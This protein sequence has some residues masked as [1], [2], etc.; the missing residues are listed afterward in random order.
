MNGAM[1]IRNPATLEPV[2]L[3][4]QAGVSDLD[5]AV[6]AAWQAFPSWS[7]DHGRRVEVLARCAARVREHL[8]ELAALLTA[9][10]GKTLAESRHEVAHV[11]DCLDFYCGLSLDDTLL[12]EVDGRRVSLFRRPIGVVGVITPWNYPLL[13]LAWKIAPA[14]VAG[15]TVVCKPAPTTPLATR[16][17]AELWEDLL[18]PAAFTVL[19]GGAELGQALVEHPDIPKVSFTGSTRTG[20]AIAQLAATRLKRV[21]LELGG[22][23]PVIVLP[24]ADLDDVAQTVGVGAFINAG[25]SCVAPKRVYAHA[26]I[27]DDLVAR[28]AACAAA[29]PV[30]PGT[31]PDAAVGPMHSA[32][33]RA[34]VLLLVEQAKAGGAHVVDPVPAAPDGPGYFLSP[35]V[36]A[37]VTDDVPLACEE[38]FGPALPVLVFDDEADAVERANAG[39]YGLGASVWSGDGERAAALA[40]DLRAGTVWVNNHMLLEVDVPFGGVKMSGLGREL[41]RAGLEEFVDTQVLSTRTA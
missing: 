30:G 23:D 2:A 22:N 39:P 26:R 38:Q 3:V 35:M 20:A 10:Q 9:E 14:L 32:A 16:R 19:P 27:H 21:T 5:A 8:D 6:A 34:F 12:K 28:L 1:E 29:M 36:L 33:Q 18:P 4:D 7:R 17:L 37:G 24:D 41:G 40:R 31:S 13:L 11:A 25:Q 15:N